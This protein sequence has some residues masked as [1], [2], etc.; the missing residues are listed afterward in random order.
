MKKTI[1][2]LLL[3]IFAISNIVCAA[4]HCV[5]AGASGNGSGSDWT[6]AY[7]SLPSTLTRGDTYYISDG[8]YG[9]Y[10]FDDA[11]MGSVYINI[12]KATSSD[13]Y[14]EIAWNESYGDGQAIFT[15]SSGNTITVDTDYWMIDGQTRLNGTSGHGFK[16]TTTA[17]S[18]GSKLFDVNENVNYVT[19]KYTE[20]EHCGYSSGY[21]QDAIYVVGSGIS[22]ITIA[23][24]WVHNVNRQPF[25]FY[26]ARNVI[27]EYNWVTEHYNEDVF[28]VHS[29]CISSNYCGSN[30]NHIYRYNVFRNMEGTT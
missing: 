12:K 27:L 2:C 14:T 22:D 24:C 4:D 6:N 29:S 21:N 25:Y 9:S 17:C 28:A 3:N 1:I 8:T 30:A 18:S 16:F 7:T 19:L 20:V 10:R 5:R 15:T 26:Q 11:A 23:Y 13:H